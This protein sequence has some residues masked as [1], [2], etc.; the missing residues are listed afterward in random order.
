MPDRELAELHGIPADRVPQAWPEVADWI[1]EACASMKGR[2][3][4]GD[5]LDALLSKDWQLWLARK[6]GKTVACCVTQ[7]VNYPRKRYGRINIGCGAGR[8]DWQHFRHTLEE[9]AK[10]HGCHGMET[11]ARPGWERVFTDYTKT[12]VFLERSFNDGQL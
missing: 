3:S 12:H 7:I 5:V 1:A 11:D 4:P 6:D 2:Y 8:E 10:A 9:W